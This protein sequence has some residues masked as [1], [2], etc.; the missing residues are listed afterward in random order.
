MQPARISFRAFCPEVPPA[1]GSG[2]PYLGTAVLSL[3][4]SKPKGKVLYSGGADGHVCSWSVTSRVER[5]DWR[6]IE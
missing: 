4:V 6:A 1:E 5:F 3:A 2:V